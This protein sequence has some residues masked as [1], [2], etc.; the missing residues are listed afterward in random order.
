M[1][2]FAG[3]EKEAGRVLAT[4]EET[5]VNTDERDSRAEGSLK[6]CVHERGEGRWIKSD[7]EEGLT[8]FTESEF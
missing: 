2:P 3:R 1:N 4:Y 8:E 6:T 7:S 5:P